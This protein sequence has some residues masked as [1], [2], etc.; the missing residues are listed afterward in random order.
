MNFSRLT[1]I[2]GV[3]ILFAGNMHAMYKNTQ[4]FDKKSFLLGNQI[5]NSCIPK[6][7]TEFPDELKTKKINPLI[8]PSWIKKQTKAFKSQAIITAGFTAGIYV[9]YTYLKGYMPATAKHVT[10]T[11]NAGV[12]NLKNFITKEVSERLDTLSKKFED[13]RKE[14]KEAHNKT[15][16]DLNQI[17]KDL[18]E[19]KRKI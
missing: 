13:F 12:E 16:Q 17:K 19:L 14:N 3:F 1:L 9:G 4:S 15:H 8:K 18:N 10:S 2:A 5:V 11:V 6:Y 7:S